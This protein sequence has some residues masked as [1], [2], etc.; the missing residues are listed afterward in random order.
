MPKRKRYSTMWAKFISARAIFPKKKPQPH[1]ELARVQ[2]VKPNARLWVAWG[3]FHFRIEGAE[4]ENVLLVARG[5]ARPPLRYT[6]SMEISGVHRGE[7]GRLGVTI[8]SA[9]M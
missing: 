5:Q 3:I 9:A 7:L 2:A 4:K 6:F 1:K 8:L